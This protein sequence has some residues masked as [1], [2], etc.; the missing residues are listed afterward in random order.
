MGL[1]IFALLSGEGAWPSPPLPYDH[2][3][4]EAA[5]TYPTDTVRLQ[6]LSDYGPLRL[7][8]SLVYPKFRASYAA[9]LAQIRLT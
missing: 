6:V 4:E 9:H 3:S 8:T 1:G 7:P 2:S 5:A